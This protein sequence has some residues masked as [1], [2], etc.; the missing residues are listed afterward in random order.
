MKEFLT[1]A[2]ALILSFLSGSV[3]AT[4][5]Q[6]LP[7]QTEFIFRTGEQQFPLYSYLHVKNIGTQSARFDAASTV[8]W[9]M[10][11]RE[12][13]P[14]AHSLT[15]PQTEAINFVLE[16]HPERLSD[17]QHSA[18]ISVQAVDLRNTAVLDSQNV[19]IILKKNFSEIPTPTAAISPVSSPTTTPIVT[20]AVS[21]SPTQ[22]PAARPVG[23]VEVSPIRPA[24]SIRVAPV[25][26]KESPVKLPAPAADTSPSAA[27]P[28]VQEQR[29]FRSIW[30]FL[31]GLFLGQ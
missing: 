4:Y 23:T 18:A 30:R 27:S 5:L 21:A 17:G 2:L 31:R 9:L 14:T 19:V 7:S 22:L 28:P 15:L 20:A 8:D 1:G 10:I 16:I 11:Y 13:Q 6:L 29:L 12:G 25:K 26:I 24:V 3:Q